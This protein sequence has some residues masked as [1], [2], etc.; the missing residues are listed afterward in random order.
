MVTIV[1]LKPYNV[2]LLA[3]PKLEHP[4]FGREWRQNNGNK[5]ERWEQRQN[6]ENIAK[7]PYPK[8]SSSL[9]NPQNS[10]MKFCEKMKLKC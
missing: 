7:I 1:N 9:N 5:I 10:E 6:D 2:R 8:V 4:K 3:V